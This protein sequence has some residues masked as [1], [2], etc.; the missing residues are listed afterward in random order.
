MRIKTTVAQ[1]PTQ[2]SGQRRSP[3]GIL[4]DER[5]LRL[6]RG[7]GRGNLYILVEVSGEEAGRNIIAMQL[8]EAICQVYYGRKGSITAGLQQALQKAN[9]LL[10]DE[11]RNA[12]PGEQRTAGV[13]CVVLRGDS[14]FVAQ[15]GPAAVFLAQEGQVTRFPERWDRLDELPP[16]EADTTPLG[17]RRDVEPSLFHTQVSQGAT[18]LLVESEWARRVPAQ[19]W[20]AILNKTPVETVL[21]ALLEMH[22]GRE[23]LALAVELSVEGAVAPLARPAATPDVAPYPAREAGPVAAPDAYQP[24]DT[25]KTVKPARPSRG[26]EV[27][28]WM[29]QLRVGDRLKTLGKALGATLLA[30]GAGLLTF[31]RGFMPGQPSS[32]PRAEEPEKKA[33]RRTRTARY[34]RMQSKSVQ[35]LLMGIAIAIPLIVAAIVLVTFLQRGQTQRV[36]METYWQE[37][38]ARWQQAQASDNPATTRALLSE[39]EDYL[40]QVLE[41]QPNHTNAQDLLKMVQ[42]RRDELDQVRRINWI[43]T[44]QTY[45]ANADLTRIIVEGVHLFVMDRQGGKVYHHQLDEYQQSLVPGTEGT[46]LVSKGEQVGDVLVGDLIDMTWMP[47]GSDRQKANLLILESGGAII[48]YDPATG[49]RIPL[50]VADWEKW[51]YPKLVGSY[52]GRFYLLDPTANQIWRYPPTPDGYSLSPDE[53][54]QSQVDLA[55]VVDMAIGDSIYL[56]YADGRIRKL[57]GGNPDTF[58][59]SDWD[60]PPNSPTA[61]FTRPPDK[62]QWV[63]VADRGNSRIVQA[64]KEGL[65]ERQFRLADLQPGDAGDPLGEVTSLFVDE[66]SGHAYFLSGGKLYMVVLPD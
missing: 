7:R 2:G 40:H 15:A 43:A 52:Y 57:S 18:F 54:L 62:T 49:E 65:F 34:A 35:R 37:A 16:D 61:L 4:V 66:I 11:N 53:W 56:L 50:R 30:L 5:A 55:G 32:E 12:L 42:A 25:Q 27:A 3:S 46:I 10:F 64:S 47:V 48:E 19:A 29:E 59:I 22:R 41:Y 23:V 45:P 21:A 36:E 26:E 44:L 24:D 58:D 13:S 51:Q 60:M 20:P 17:D 14:L 1:V 6:A 28:P 31:L 39:A 38:N 63:Y 9:R 33:T 8:A